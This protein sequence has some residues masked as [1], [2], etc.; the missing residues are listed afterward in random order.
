MPLK[1]LT[2]EEPPAQPLG[3]GLNSTAAV[4]SITPATPLAPGTSVSVQFTFGVVQGG[5]FRA[6]VNTEAVTDSPAPP[7]FSPNKGGARLTSSPAA[8]EKQDRAGKKKQ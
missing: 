1:A 8:S 7:P 5:S 4:V 3:G 2:V 6:F